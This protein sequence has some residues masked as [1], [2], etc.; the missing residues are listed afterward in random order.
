MLA[1]FG[2]RT[3]QWLSQTFLRL[4]GGLGLFH[5][6][7]SPP[8]FHPGSNFH[9]GRMAHPAF[10]GSFPIF[11]HTGNNKMLICFNSTWAS[12]SQ[13]TQMNTFLSFS[14]TSHPT[15]KPCLLTSIYNQD[16]TASRHHPGSSYHHLSPDYGNSLL[17]QA[18]WYMKDGHKFIV[19][20]STLLNLALASECFSQ[21]HIEEAMLCQA[22]RR[23]SASASCLLEP[24][25]HAVWKP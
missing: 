10:P 11:F 19:L 25:L 13:K 9:H 3:L 15:S 12:A 17:S 4:H 23:L 5:P 7:L 6:T 24:S 8:P 21:L 14:H 16:L 18:A 2:L 1:N 22:L 20:L